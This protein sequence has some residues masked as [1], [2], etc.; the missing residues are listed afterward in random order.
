MKRLIM[1]TFITAILCFS[2]T[3]IAVAPV[4]CD[5]E[6][7]AGFMTK[8]LNALLAHDASKLPVT[9]NVKYTENGVRLNLTDGL[10]RTA[11][12]MPTYRV[13]VIK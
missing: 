1:T 9:K 3:A 6:C 12:A 11:S 7:L 5:R 13:D 4:E 2:L 8:Y 10:W